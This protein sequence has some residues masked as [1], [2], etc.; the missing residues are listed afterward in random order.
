MMAAALT[1]GVRQPLVKHLDA[2]IR[3]I[4]SSEAEWEWDRPLM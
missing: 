4:E 2:F 1:L 3:G